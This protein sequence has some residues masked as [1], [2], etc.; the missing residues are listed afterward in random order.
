[1]AKI[2][3]KKYNPAYVEA[4]VKE[5]LKNKDFYEYHKY[6]KRP[7]FSIVLPPPNITGKLHLGHA[8]DASL[9]D[10]IIRYKHL[11]G[12]N[13]LWVSGMDHASIATQTKYEKLLKE[14]EGKSRF[15]FTR[16][17]FLNKLSTWSNEQRQFIAKQWDSLNLALSLKS[18]CFTM[19]EHVHQACMEWFVDAYKQGL[20]YQDYKLVNWD[21]QLQTAISDIEVIYKETNSKMY[22]F[23]Y[24][25]QDD[26]RFLTVA[27]TRPETMFGD[28][29]LVINPKD[30]HNAKYIGRTAINPA[31][32][33]PLPIIGDEYVELGFGTGI[34]KC[35][36]AHDFNDY[37]L[38]KKHHI[39]LYKNVMNPNGTMNIEAVDFKGDS[40]NMLTVKEARQRLVEALQADGKVAKIEDIVNN[41]GY[42]ERTN[43]IVEP[44]ISKQWFVRMQPLCKKIIEAQ[45]KNKGVEFIPA[46]FNDAL[47][48]W[49]NNIQDW[50]ISRQLWWGH[51]LPVYYNKTNGKVLVTTKPPKDKDK[52]VQDPDVLDTW[53]S[54]GLWPLVCTS[55]RKDKKYKDF[56]PTSLL[57]TAYDILFF[58]IARM[59]TMCNHWSKKLP[60][61]QVLIHGL[62]RDSQ[63]RK[64]SKSLGNG[65]D[66]MDLIAKYGSD[67]M[68]MFFTSSAT[69]GEDLRFNEE[70]IIYY[71]SVLNKMW[72]SYN[73]ISGQRVKF[74]TKDLN[75]FDCWM[76]DKLN[77]LIVQLT[78][79]YNKYDFT[80]ANKALI[81][82]FWNDF[83]NQYLE[84]I[85]INLNDKKKA[86]KQKAVAL[87]IFDEFLKLFYPIAPAITDYLFYEINHKYIW[88]TN[89]KP[90]KIK[91][92]FDRTLIKHFVNITNS[93]RDYRIKNGL[94]RKN[95]IAFDYVTT[96]K[97]NLNELNK[98][99]AA[100]AI[101][102]NNIINV[103]P[104]NTTALVVEDGIICLPQQENKTEDLAK[105]L[106]VVE[107]EI[108]RA[109]GMLNN[110]NFVAKA[111]AD[112][113]QAERDKLAKYE[114]EK[115]QI[116]LSLNK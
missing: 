58:W 104:E 31:N 16:Q 4:R 102:V 95:E 28:C 83:C 60:F 11:Q 84:F 40:Y 79:Q 54:S 49:L 32:G 66:P 20:I 71:W 87:F 37:N 67:A 96:D 34:M 14:T 89:V 62:I 33:K 105:R 78:E 98:L 93:L 91:Y 9:Q 53:F 63:G 61:N 38:A 30:Q 100:F 72:N 113:V 114:A 85:K 101:K 18:Q 69:M 7:N 76:L 6:S 86:K 97:F 23:K 94:S 106:E 77:K 65:V 29:C 90:L 8:W 1:M 116:L 46:R 52:W 3:S 51:Q 70:K 107:F 74:T 22:Y 80:V 88:F 48:T 35:T 26:Y 5:L 12:F 47:L 42:S 112:K 73:L 27:T 45:N 99:L 81:D 43:T 15:D 19:D 64:M 17:E 10:A 21:T 75:P 82:C 24:Y 109:Q 110:A 115:Q 59:M 25:L 111:P 57:V 44:Y 55:W 68:K 36:P 50:C 103:K 13:T 92:E 2:D 56:Y 41:I 39:V 108:K